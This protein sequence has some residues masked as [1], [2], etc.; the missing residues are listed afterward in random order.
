MPQLTELKV[1][2]D[3]VTETELRCLSKLVSL[4]NL[5]L[6]FSGRWPSLRAFVDGQHLPCLRKLVLTLSGERTISYTLGMRIFRPLVCFIDPF[7]Q[8]H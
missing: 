4:S 6:T 3:D 2:L 7:P 1:A 5:D 8:F